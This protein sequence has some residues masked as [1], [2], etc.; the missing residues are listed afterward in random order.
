MVASG[1]RDAADTVRARADHGD[2]VA[3]LDV[4]EHA[5]GDGV[6]LHVP[7]SPPRDGADAATARTNDLGAP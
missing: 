7:A 4:D 5:T 3:G 6:V 1:Q 2:L